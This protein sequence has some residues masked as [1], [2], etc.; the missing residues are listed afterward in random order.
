[1]GAPL[2]SMLHLKEVI[3]CVYDMSLSTLRQQTGSLRRRSDSILQRHSVF[4]III[5]SLLGG[6]LPAIPNLELRQEVSQ[7]ADGQHGDENGELDPDADI[8]AVG[9]RKGEA[10]RLPEAVV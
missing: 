6:Q 2:C 1:M 8:V 4:L 9:E 10:Q 3:A 7:H 5:S